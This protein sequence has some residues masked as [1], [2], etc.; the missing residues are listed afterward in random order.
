MRS[1]GEKW[2]PREWGARERSRGPGSEGQGKE[3]GGKGE[4]WG[5][6]SE[7][8]GRELGGPGSEGQGRKGLMKMLH[9]IE[10]IYQGKRKAMSSK[11]ENRKGLKRFRFVFTCYPDHAPYVA[12]A[13]TSTAQV[14]PRV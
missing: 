9:F 12:N 14:R 11:M 1:R 8:K 4:K 10:L 3:V 2:G 5:P 13:H 6:G 7:G